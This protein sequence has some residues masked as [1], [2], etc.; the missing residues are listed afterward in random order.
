[1]KSSRQEE[2]EERKR[3][4]RREREL[5]QQRIAGIAAERMRVKEREKQRKPFVYKSRKV[6]LA[7]Q[8]AKVITSLKP[9]DGKFDNLVV[10]E[11]HLYE[12]GVD[13]IAMSM[14]TSEGTVNLVMSAETADRIAYEL[15][16]LVQVVSEPND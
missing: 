12:L 10:R 6:I 13:R 1:V 11:Y 2:V 8:Q 14:M 15:A 5:Q 3:Q 7:E 4:R 9:L 16:R